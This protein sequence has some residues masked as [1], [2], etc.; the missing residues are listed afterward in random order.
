MKFLWTLRLSF[1]QV[2]AQDLKGTLHVPFGCLPRFLDKWKETK[3]QYD[4]PSHTVYQ[5]NYHLSLHLVLPS[6]HSS[7][8]AIRLM[9]TG[10]KRKGLFYMPSFPPHSFY[11]IPH[12]PHS[13]FN[14]ITAPFHNIK[15]SPP[16]KTVI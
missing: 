9:D 3:V 7:S 2:K 1:K 5:V 6:T 8:R 11:L 4:K 12:F 16:T 14:Q 13:V 10:V 15:T